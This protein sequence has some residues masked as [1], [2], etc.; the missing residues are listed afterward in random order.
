MYAKAEA[1]YY[2]PLE[3]ELPLVSA[4]IQKFD[5]SLKKIKRQQQAFAHNP[6]AQSVFGLQGAAAQTWRN[7]WL[8]CMHAEVRYLAQ[9]MWGLI[10]LGF[11][12][13]EEQ[14]QMLMYDP[15]LKATPQEIELYECTIR[16]DGEGPDCIIIPEGFEPLSR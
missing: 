14:A 5:Q 13:V 1:L 3:A 9:E 10:S 12:L 11:P 8:G 15:Q 6:V 16:D 7:T 4:A 2:R